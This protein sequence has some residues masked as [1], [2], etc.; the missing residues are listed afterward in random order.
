MRNG[1]V[2][3]GGLA[4]VAFVDGGLC[5]D[6]LVVG[7]AVF[8]DRWVDIAGDGSAVAMGRGGHPRRWTS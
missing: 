1:P 3:G 5:C 7:G 8:L 4:L 2:G 6:V